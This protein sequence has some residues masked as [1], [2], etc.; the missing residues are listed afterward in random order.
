MNDTKEK[1]KIAIRWT[2]HEDKYRHK[3]R[4]CYTTIP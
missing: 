1:R 4:K 2:N 3:V